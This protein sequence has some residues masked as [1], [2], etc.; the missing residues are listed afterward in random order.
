MWLM[1]TIALALASVLLLG[2]YRW[3]LREQSLAVGPA[4]R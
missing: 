2:F 3:I 4:P 1:Q